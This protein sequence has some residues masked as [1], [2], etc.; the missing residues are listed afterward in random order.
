MFADEEFKIT[1]ELSEITGN[2]MDF[3][4]DL[5]N[6]IPNL[7]LFHQQQQSNI[8][9]IAVHSTNFLNQAKSNFLSGRVEIEGP[10]EIRDSLKCTSINHFH[11][12]MFH[13]S[14]SCLS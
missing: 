10:F 4:N 13:I 7:T 8:S 9:I 14:P 5:E 2:L 6:D 12:Q 1:K 3:A 11:I